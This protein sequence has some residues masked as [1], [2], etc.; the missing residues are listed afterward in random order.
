[1]G[2]AP[3]INL[4]DDLPE[5]AHALGAHDAELA[6][7]HCVVDGIE[8]PPGR[9]VPPRSP[10]PEPGELGLLIV[11]G[12]VTRDVRLG[13]SIACE[14]CG[15]G[16]V[17]RPSDHDGEQAPVPFAVEW[18]ALGPLRVA[19]LDRRATKVLGH[20]PEIVEYL[21]RSC[22]KRS[23]SLGLHLAV[24][25]LRR[26][27]P[28]LL[29]MLWHLAD[30]W[31]RVTPDGVH[32]PVRLTHQTLGQLIGAQRPSVTTGLKGLGA[33]GA[34]SRRPDGTWMLHGEPPDLLA[35]LVAADAAAG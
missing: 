34:V 14:L 7:V 1:V 30:R 24:G 19:I 9:W 2:P 3:R 17:L 28:R 5:L 25:H 4:I 21:V 13:S 10:R 27:E 16:D 11:D 31:G 35:Q 23:R 33:A 8:V 20:W 15:R 12:F 26:V 6:R 32:V 18:R 29:V 22:V